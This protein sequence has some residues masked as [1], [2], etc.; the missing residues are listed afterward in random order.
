MSK[1][2]L[3]TDSDVRRLER[4]LESTHS[5]SA[6]ALQALEQELDR[7]D[8]VASASVAANV[9]T[10]HSRVRVHDL[11]RDSE[12]VCTIV[13]PAEANAEHNRVSVL[14]PLGTALLGYRVGQIV[15]FTA[16]G[17][18]RRIKIV[19]IEYQPEAA[20]RDRRHQVGSPA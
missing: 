18:M 20:A 5:P 2:I 14:A 9:V 11:D 15:R 10:M 7:A 8:I 6:P 17:G 12:F 16:P 3:V 19:A 13:F 1:R 4:L